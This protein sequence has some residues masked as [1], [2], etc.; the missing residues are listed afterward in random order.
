MAN[1]AAAKLAEK[2]QEEDIRRLAIEINKRF[3]ADTWD[4]ILDAQKVAI[5]EQKK[6]K[7]EEAQE[8]SL[9]CL[10]TKKFNTKNIY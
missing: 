6:R 7:E 5:A 10:T 8:K 1:V 9:C 4:E 2:Q 3:G